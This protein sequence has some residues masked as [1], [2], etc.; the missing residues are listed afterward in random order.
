MQQFLKEQSQKYNCCK[1]IARKSKTRLENTN[2]KKYILKKRSDSYYYVDIFLESVAVS[3]LREKSTKQ[4]SLV[5]EVT[6]VFIL[7]RS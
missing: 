7:L 1:M 3:S 4:K 6:C 2:D 5:E